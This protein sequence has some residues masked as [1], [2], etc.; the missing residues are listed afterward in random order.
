MIQKGE[1][2]DLYRELNNAYGASTRSNNLFAKAVKA[3][4]WDKI[5]EADGETYYIK[6]DVTLTV[7]NLDPFK[8][9]WKPS[10]MIGT[11]T[12]DLGL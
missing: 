5:F 1:H 12:T 2:M 4:R 10:V 8:A 11:F 9:L 6:G 3:V 7:E